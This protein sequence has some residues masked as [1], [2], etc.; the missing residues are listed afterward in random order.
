[1]KL[2][3]ELHTLQDAKAATRL[4]GQECSQF[5]AAPVELYRGMTSSDSISKVAIRQD[6][7]PLDTNALVSAS[8]NYL[9]ERKHSTPN[10]RSRAMFCTPRKTQ[11]GTYGVLHWVIP[12]DEC[13]MWVRAGVRDSLSTMD[14]IEPFVKMFGKEDIEAAK[15]AGLPMHSGEMIAHMYQHGSK[16]TRAVI[17]DMVQSTDKIFR[18]YK[19]YNTGAGNTM[20]QYSEVMVT[21]PSY[22]AIPVSWAVETYG[23]P[24][25]EYTFAQII[26]DATPA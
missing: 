4:L 26:K 6:R 23:I 11:A 25:E 20:P 10:I 3:Q 24:Y 9:F 21:G 18:E 8:F 7:R 19:Q 5:V 13:V 14:D 2:L 22:F 12:T 1:M 15:S 17:D 16:Q